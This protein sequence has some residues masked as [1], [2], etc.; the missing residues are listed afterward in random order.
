[1]DDSIKK[2]GAKNSTLLIPDVSNGK[3]SD[4]NKSNQELFTSI[5]SGNFEVNP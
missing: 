3:V 1:M 4:K 2:S 5:Y